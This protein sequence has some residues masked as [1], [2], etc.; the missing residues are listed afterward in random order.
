MAAAV[1]A[2]PQGRSRVME[3]VGSGHS[4]G[5]SLPWAWSGRVVLNIAVSIG[6]SFFVPRLFANIFGVKEAFLSEFD[7]M[8]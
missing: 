4:G 8:V 5:Y 6:M 2:R 7:Q 1:A 3:G